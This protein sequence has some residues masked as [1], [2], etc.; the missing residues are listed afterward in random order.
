MELYVCV[1]GNNRS[2]RSGTSW[3][4]HMSV[5]QGTTD[6]AEVARVDGII[7]LCYREQQI[8]QKWHELMEL[9]VCVTGNNRSCRSGTSW[10][11]YMSVLQGTTDPAEVARVDGVICLCYREQQILQ[12]WHELME[13]YVCVTGNNRSCRSGTSWWNYMSVLQ[14]TTDPAEVARVDGII[15]LCY[16]E[17]QILQKWHELMESY[18]CVTGNNRSCRSGTSWWNYMS[19]L[20]GTTDPAEVARVDGVICLCYRE[21]QILQKWHELMELYVCVTGNNRSCRSG[22]SWWN[23]MSVL[24]GTTDPAEVARVDGVI[25]LCYREQQIL[26]KWHELMELYV[27]VTGNNRSCRSGTSWWSH[28]SVLQGTTDPAEVARVDGVTG[29]EEADSDRLQWAA[30]DVPGDGEYPSGDEGDG[31]RKQNYFM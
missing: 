31:G 13:L 14:G 6:P 29:E 19:V 8:L 26:Q 30:G 9:Y 28:M 22:T 12:K 7:C 18:V 20:Q 4:S 15:C 25:C 27:C 16:R 3:W 10:W 21:Q 23:Y 24:Q 2:C 5:L 17:Q 11:N 1:T